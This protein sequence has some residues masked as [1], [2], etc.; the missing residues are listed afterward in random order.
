MMF[1]NMIALVRQRFFFSFLFHFHALI[2]FASPSKNQPKNNLTNK[3]M[4][5]EVY[6]MTRLEDNM[7]FMKLE[8][9]INNARTLNI[10]N[11]WFLE[12]NDSI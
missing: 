2:V 9:K 3:T 7:H 5:N 10:Q 1:G 4:E 6:F 11:I 12:L 8:I